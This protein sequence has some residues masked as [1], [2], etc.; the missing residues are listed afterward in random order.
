MNIIRE[1]TSRA[2]LLRLVRNLERKATTLEEI[3]ASQNEQI[4]EL[5]R[6]GAP[7]LQVLE[8]E[9]CARNEREIERCRNL[10][11]GDLELDLAK[12]FGSTSWAKRLIHEIVERRGA[13]DER[14]VPQSVRRTGSE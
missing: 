12:K 8:L 11:D 7:D 10:N 13:E 3:V 2:S 4:A 14:A 1:L 6:A 9:Q 5:E